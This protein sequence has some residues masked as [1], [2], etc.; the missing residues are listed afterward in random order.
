MAKANNDLVTGR[1]VTTKTTGS[2][3]G[4]GSGKGFEAEECRKPATKTTEASS[5]WTIGKLIELVY[6]LKL[7]HW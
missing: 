4:K 3:V 1:K 6:L 2:N 5:Q 7:R